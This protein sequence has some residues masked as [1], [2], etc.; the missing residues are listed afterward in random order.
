MPHAGP[1]NPRPAPPVSAR[2]TLVLRWLG[3]L[4]LATAATACVRLPDP[5][6]ATIRTPVA[7]NVPPPLYPDGKPYRSTDQSQ[8]TVWLLADNL[9]TAMVFP[10]DWL[11][12]SGFVPPAGFG[13]PPFVNF[14]WGD[15]TAY[16]Q[17]EWLT[18]W[19]VFRALFTP[20]PSVM[21]IIP[22]DGYV[23]EICQQQRVWRKLVPRDQGPQIANFLN[24]VSRTGPDGRPIV[25]GPS[26]WG[27][28]FLMESKYSYY[29]PR[30]CN[31]WTAQAMEAAGCRVFPLTGLTA[32][33]LIRQAEAPGNGFACVWLGDG[34]KVQPAKETVPKSPPPAGS[35]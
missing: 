30:I 11:L 31:V 21:E 34:T 17:H 2:R 18:P 35:P 24:H 25:I 1:R 5:P 33:G 14:S 19:Q 22:I 9:H 32:N 6:P 3:V 29:L 15:R 27:K 28:G 23:A 7:T 8:V 12:A 20:T 26:S 16:V 10:Y 4:A 13:N